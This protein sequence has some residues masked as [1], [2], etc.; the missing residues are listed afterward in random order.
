MDMI[1]R[2]IFSIFA[3]GILVSIC[4]SSVCGGEIRYSPSGEEMNAGPDRFIIIGQYTNVF[5]D[6]DGNPSTLL[7]PENKLFIVGLKKNTDYI[8]LRYTPYCRFA[9]E[10]VYY[11]PFLTGFGVPTQTGHPLRETGESGFIIGYCTGVNSIW[12]K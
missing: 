8:I 9:Q 3:I 12:P 2:K 1:G 7:S 11:H 5:T 6:G 4:F 10:I